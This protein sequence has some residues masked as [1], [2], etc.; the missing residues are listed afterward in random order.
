MFSGM[1]CPKN[2]CHCPKDL[3]IS[4]AV[5]DGVQ[6]GGEDSVEDSQNLIFC[7]RTETFRSKISVDKRCI[8]K[9]HHS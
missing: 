3:L 6:H 1:E 7:G 8:V 5:D 2:S 9:C 4:Q